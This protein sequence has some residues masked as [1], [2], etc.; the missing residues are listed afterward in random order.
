[1]FVGRHNRFSFLC[2]HPA[3]RGG[4]RTVQGKNT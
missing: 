1:L 2:D 3:R 4:T